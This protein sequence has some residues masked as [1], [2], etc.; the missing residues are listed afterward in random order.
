M[1]TKFLRRWMWSS[2]PENESIIYVSNVIASCCQEISGMWFTMSMDSKKITRR[3]R[4][5]TFRVKFW[6]RATAEQASQHA[7]VGSMASS[8]M[9]AM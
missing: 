7:M 3:P 1:R 6:E 8:C 5:A 4:L 9:M 2:R